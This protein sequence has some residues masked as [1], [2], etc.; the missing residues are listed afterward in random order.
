MKRKIHISSALLILNISLV[1]CSLVFL[2]RNAKNYLD[3]IILSKHDSG[4]VELLARNLL[5][6]NYLVMGLLLVNLIVLIV[7]VGMGRVKQ[8][9][10]GHFS[11]R[12]RNQSKQRGF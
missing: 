7:V 4:K 8:S 2:G 9:E 5:E 3:S 6:L 11:E 10:R 12:S 1:A